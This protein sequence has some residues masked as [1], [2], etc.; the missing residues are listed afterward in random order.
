MNVHTSRLKREGAK[1]CQRTF[2]P[3]HFISS[4]AANICKAQ[5]IIIIICIK[6]E[7]LNK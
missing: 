7:I 4:L 3:F 5:I 1:L 2:W 6:R